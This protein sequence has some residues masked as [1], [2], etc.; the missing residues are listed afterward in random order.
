M[1]CPERDLFEDP[2][3]VDLDE[4]MKH[5]IA[6]RADVGPRAVTKRVVRP[7]AGVG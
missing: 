2:H 7:N 3:S 4:K 5:R 1:P 6:S